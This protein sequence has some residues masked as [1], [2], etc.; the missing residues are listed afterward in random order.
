METKFDEMK[1]VYTMQMI[2]HKENNLIN[3]RTTLLFHQIREYYV[4]CLNRIIRFF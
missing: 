4:H 2:A 3:L 1:K